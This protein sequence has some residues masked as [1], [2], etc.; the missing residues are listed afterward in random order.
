MKFRK[1][2]I[3][4]F[5]SVLLTGCRPE[6][7]AEIPTEPAVRDLFA[8]DTYMNLKVWSPD[9]DAVLDQSAVLIADLEKLLSVTNPDSDTSRINQ[10]AGNF[11]AVSD[12]TANLIQEAVLIGSESHGALDITIYPVLKEWGFT[13]GNYQIPDENTLRNLLSHVDYTQIQLEENQVRIPEEFQIDFGSL[14]KGY[15]SDQLIA[16]FRNHQAESAI[17]NL[18]GNVQA[19]GRK[20]DGSL[21]NV[22][23]VNPLVPEENL[24]VVRIENQAVITSGNYERYFIGDDDHIYW[25]IIDPK[26]GY[27]ADNGLISVTIIGES[28]LLCDALSTALFAEGTEQAVEHY[29]HSD[30]FEMILVTDDGKILLSEGMQENFQNLSSF[31]VEVI[32]RE[33]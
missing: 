16:L 23:I 12:H 6:K 17:V 1:M 19:L 9:G 24:G 2:M 30:D 11:I 32:A 4:L 21:W 31:P 28:G 22:G 13:T 10:N 20:P 29:Q 14:A 33:K 27:P 25:H 18:G 15:T 5:L 3:L 7:N 8:M 26:D